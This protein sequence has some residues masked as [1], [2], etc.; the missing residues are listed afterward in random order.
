M[1]P[2]ALGEL[3]ERNVHELEVIALQ[4]GNV[5][6]YPV[7]NIPHCYAGGLQTLQAPSPRAL[8]WAAVMAVRYFERDSV[9]HQ[10]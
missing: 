1:L 5:P 3:R 8:A 7:D 2:H 6:L 4:D 9:G 10:S